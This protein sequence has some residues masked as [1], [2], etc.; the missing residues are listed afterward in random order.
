ME[1]DSN[2]YEVV[3][4]FAIPLPTATCR[5]MTIPYCRCHRQWWQL[6][7]SPRPKSG[8]RCQGDEQSRMW[9]LVLNQFG[10]IMISL[11]SSLSVELSDI[12]ICK[13][14]NLLWQEWYCSSKT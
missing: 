2:T 12:H 4:A 10:S 14:I 13:E 1:E 8:R 3:S 5:I 6:P 11:V 7:S 9:L